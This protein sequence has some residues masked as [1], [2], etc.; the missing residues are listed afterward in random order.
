MENLLTKIGYVSD[1][2]L[3]EKILNGET[4]LFEILIRRYNSFLYKIAR[5]YGLNHQDAQDLMQETHFAIYLQLKKFQGRSSYKT[6][7]ARIH[8]NNCFH[9]TKY[10]HYK[11]EEPNTDLTADDNTDQLM[12]ANKQETE[13]VVINKE[14]T[15]VLEEALLQLPVIYRS[16]FVLREV[17]GFSVAE[18]SELLN[19]T[20]VNVKV[21]LSRAKAMLQKQLEKYYSTTELFEFN[22]IYCDKIVQNVFERIATN[23]S[24]G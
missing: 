17:E 20:S 9:K 21:R 24:I 4:P 2:M 18:T 16:V 7:I 23:N 15:K 6:W 8:L 14:L 11:Y 5:S 13:Q 12:F 19:L 10:G 3:I 1:E 22:L